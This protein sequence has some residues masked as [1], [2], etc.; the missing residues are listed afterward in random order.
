M[1]SIEALTFSFGGPIILD[2]SK[3][4]F[5]EGDVH[6]IIGLNG[7]GKTTFFNLLSKYIKLTNGKIQF[8]NKP[9]IRADIGFLETD[10]YFYP[11]ITGQE[12][13]NIFKKT[14]DDFD[15]T[16]LQKYLELP[17]SE[18][19][20]TYSTGMK[21]LALLAIL[22]QDK[23]FYLFDEPFNGLDM[24]AN[25][26]LEIIIHRL[27]NKNKTLFIS[28]HILEPLITV[29]D[30]IHILE[31]GTFIKSYSKQEF[32]QIENELFGRLKETAKHVIEKSV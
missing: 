24:E 14:N 23:L 28:S 32:G 20:E 30:C 8:K 16:A 26:I 3:K 12:Y 21:K 7:S 31:K 29:C 11:L 17:L 5:T 9:I 25:K 4:T 10:N 22:K 1:I 6:G 13:L 18:L 15:L 27:R 19:I 2:I